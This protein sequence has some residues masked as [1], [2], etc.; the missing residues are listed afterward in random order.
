MIVFI[1]EVKQV[2]AQAG[3]VLGAETESTLATYRKQ[4]NASLFDL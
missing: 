2:A 4:L 3:I 1:E